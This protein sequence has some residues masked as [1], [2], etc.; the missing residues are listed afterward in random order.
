MDKKEAEVIGILLGD[1]YISSDFK[2]VKVSVDSNKDKEYALYIQ[3]LFSKRYKLKVNIHKKKN[4]N[5]LDLRISN[6]KFAK[7]LVSNVGLTTS[8]KLFKA[9]IPEHYF[10]SVFS[11]RVLRGLFDTDGCV[12]IANNNGNKYPRLE[13]KISESPM[14]Y[15]IIQLLKKFHFK[16]GVYRSNINQVR[17]QMN[18]KEQLKRWTC[19]IGFS[20]IK[21]RKKTEIF[22]K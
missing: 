3:K 13:I 20:N 5:T 18:G 9:T 21:H 8:P 19:L 6:K 2:E 7:Y 1:G 10:K 15:Q 17:I 14:K 12:V 22:L 4:E 16:F 11:K